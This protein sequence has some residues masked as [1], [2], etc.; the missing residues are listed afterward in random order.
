MTQKTLANALELLE[1]FTR[2]NPVWGG[3]ELAKVSGVHPAIVQRTL[4]TFASR[5]YL[6]QDPQTLKYSLGVRFFELGQMVKERLQ[7]SDIVRPLMARL[8]EQTGEAVFLSLRDGAESV[9]VDRVESP[10]SIGFKVQVG[11]KVPIYAGAYGKVILAY[12]DE[13]SREEILAQGLT[14]VTENTITDVTL[15]RTQL[16][17]IRAQGW[18]YSEQEV[19]EDVFGLAVPLFFRD[20]QVAGS[21]A[22]AG[23]LYRFDKS[24]IPHLVVSLQAECPVIEQALSAFANKAV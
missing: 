21:L 2:E 15:M 19:S 20:K 8:A 5:G 23:P 3:R 16:E 18:C 7:L 14:A 24:N 1:F 13:T 9:C 12:M 10:K 11:S 6:H 4:A 22:I 17:E